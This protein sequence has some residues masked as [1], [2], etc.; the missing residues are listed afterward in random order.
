[1]RSMREFSTRADSQHSQVSHKMPTVAWQPTYMAM[2]ACVKAMPS[3]TR[4]DDV[5]RFAQDYMYQGH[6]SACTAKHKISRCCQ[7]FMSWLDF[8]QSTT[9]LVHSPTC[10]LCGRYLPSYCLTRTHH[11]RA[12]RG[13]ES[14]VH[15]NFRA[16]SSRLPQVC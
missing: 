8:I 14:T 15:H 12:E 2:R 11:H 7:C 13:Y 4:N 3:G 6:S 9:T 16:N 1:M 5:V 10:S